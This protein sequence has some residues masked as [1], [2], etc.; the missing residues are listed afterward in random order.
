M[1]TVKE[2]C[3]RSGVSIRT[4]H[5]YDAVGL[6]PP[7]AVTDAGYRLYD[8]QALERLQT[9]LLFKELGFSL[10]EINAILAQ[11]DFDH[12][13]ALESQIALLMLQKERLEKMIDLA[14][15]IYET[16]VSH[17]DF[18]A[19]SKEELN[20]FSKEA[21]ERFGY[22][23]AYKEYEEKA[24]GHSEVSMAAMQGAMMDIFRQIGE[25]KELSPEAPEAQTLVKELKDFISRH[26]YNCTL[27]ILQSLGKMYTA[28]ERF[29]ANI[30][31]AG[32]N[33]TADFARRAIEAYCRENG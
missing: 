27:E 11:P 6:L 25:V 26:F 2:M 10:K 15:E 12:R 3:K 33:G 18:S 22:T 29:Q 4:L 31:R 30:D 28:D 14:R 7:A 16:G 5:H 23:A 32:G 20:A 9:I 24:K 21:K 19:F 13:A 8:D 17:L 1:M